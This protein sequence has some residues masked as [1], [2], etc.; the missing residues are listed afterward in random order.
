[1][2]IRITRCYRTVSAAAALFLARTPP[3]TLLARERQMLHELGLRSNGGDAKKKRWT[4]K[5]I[6]DLETWYERPFGD[7]DYHTTQAL[8]N[9]GNFQAYL[10]RFKLATSNVCSQCDSGE[11]DRANHTILRCEAFA[12]Q[13]IGIVA[14]S[15][16]EMKSWNRKFCV[17]FDTSPQG[18]RRLEL[19]DSEEQL[20]KG[21]SG[22]I[23]V[24]EDA[25]KIHTMPKNNKETNLFEITTEK[26]TLQLRTENTKELSEWIEKLRKVCFPEKQSIVNMNNNGTKSNGYS[27][28]END[29]YGAVED[30]FP[31]KLIS[32]PASEKCGLDPSE[33]NY[34]IVLTPD[35]MILKFGDLNNFYVNDDQADKT[36]YEWHYPFIRRYG[37]VNGFF[38]FEAGRKCLSGEG[39]F[40]FDAPDVRKIFERLASFMKLA[41]EKR[42]QMKAASSPVQTA[43]DIHLPKSNVCEKVPQDE[44]CEGC[45]KL[46]N[47]N[48]ESPDQAILFGRAC[49]V[50]QTPISSAVY[51]NVTDLETVSVD[52]IVVG[53][54]VE[55]ARVIKSAT[56]VPPPPPPPIQRITRMDSVEKLEDAC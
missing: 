12:H 17:L 52:H 51:A 36:I 37:I 50:P 29:L 35:S 7:V 53:D 32:T 8:T 9:H 4:S 44:N 24:L 42:K 39:L 40:S 5:C 56:V 19:F 43:E 2:A 33:L 34:V 49:A 38:S 27:V 28:K 30:T 10:H 47:G 1:M 6:P 54:G 18:V 55:Y 14:R 31:V 11:A 26:R 15:T 20:A 22:K 3:G 23:L 48:A 21:N 46:S 41:G 13:R 25:V 16:P 45:K